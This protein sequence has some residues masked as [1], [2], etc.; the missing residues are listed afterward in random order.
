MFDCLADWMTVPFLYQEHTG[1]APGRVGLNHPS[2]AP[3][4]AYQVE[5]GELVVISIQN[6]A[7]WVSFCTHILNDPQLI[8]DPR[9]AGNEERVENR[10]LLNAEIDAVFGNTEK[11]E[12]VARLRSGRIAYGF[13]NSV[14]DFCAHPQLR[15]TTVQTPEG[16]IDIIAPPVRRA[17]ET[18][19]LR[20]VPALGE[21]T[22]D[23]MRE[24]ASTGKEQVPSLA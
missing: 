9:F 14:K 10:A 4:G 11:Q 6:H 16:P 17:G 1:I 12:L 15:R 19:S 18:A 20:P 3:Y 2:I 5:T 8:E 7:E 13:V 21:H 23:L 22:N 24:F